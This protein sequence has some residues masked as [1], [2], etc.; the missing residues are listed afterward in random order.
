MIT[1]KKSNK[2]KL[3]V[4]KLKKIIKHKLYQEDVNFGKD[5]KTKDYTDKKG[6]VKTG[7]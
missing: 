2:D 5:Y 4:F 7:I 3:E 1:L 6:P